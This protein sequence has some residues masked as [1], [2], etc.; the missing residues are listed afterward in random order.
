V[1]MRPMALSAA[2]NHKNFKSIRIWL[3]I[4]VCILLLGL[5][6]C[7]PEN[8]V[9]LKK[10]ENVKFSEIS[11]KGINL[12]I[13]AL[14]E[15]RS[16]YKFRINDANLDIMLN[17]VSIGQVKLAKDC[18]IKRKSTASYNFRVDASY[19]DLLAGGIAS[20]V[21]LAFKK[22]IRCTCKGWIEVRK[23]GISRKI[24]VEFDQ[25]VSLGGD[26]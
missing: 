22:K 11:K 20:L 6:S 3:P 12:E 26:T 14:I 25:D 5:T 9:E 19:S 13:V 7:V 24:P 10:I 17:Q 16:G 8:P 21:N 2:V 15:N 23:W 4:F 1:K 18:V